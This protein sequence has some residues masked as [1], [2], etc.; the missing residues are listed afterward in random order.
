M[1]DVL[2]RPLR[3]GDGTDLAQAWLDAGVYYTRHNPEYFQVPAV[4]GLAAWLDTV[5]AATSDDDLSIVAECDAKAVGF[6]VARIR[7][8]MQHAAKHYVREVTQTCLMIDG[9]G[10]EERYWRRGIATRLMATAEAWGRE[11]GARIALLDTYADS[12]L[13]VPF[14][15]EH[16]GFS[17]R[18]VRFRKALD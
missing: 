10:V 17:R 4:E 9:L 1:D 16:L 18:S 15:E 8:P 14:Y 6:L 11:R 13:S 3:P 2:I 7:P 12:P 5:L